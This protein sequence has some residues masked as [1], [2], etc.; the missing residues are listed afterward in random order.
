MFVW[1]LFVLVP[2]AAPVDTPSVARQTSE[3]ITAQE[4]DERAIAEFNRAVDEYVVLHRRLESAFPPEQP[5]DDPEE[6]IE[7][8]KGLADAIRRA[9]PDARPGNTFTP[10]SAYVFRRL[11][12]DLLSH[13]RH[14]PDT[15]IRRLNDPLPG[16][17]RPKVNGRYD[18]ELGASMWPALLQ[19][20]PRLPAELQYRIVGEDLVLIDLRANLVVD[21]LEHALPAGEE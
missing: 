12:S 4:M 2:G 3:A 5:F 10:G 6:M 15:L 17:K 16:A 14:D 9:R 7:A 11:I 19:V 20:L 13:Y 18:W 21:I 8:A 1:L